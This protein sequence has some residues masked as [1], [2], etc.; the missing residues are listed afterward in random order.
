MTVM[1]VPSLRSAARTA[2]VVGALVAA[3]APACTT[4]AKPQTKYVPPSPIVRTANARWT[5]QAVV[6]DNTNGDVTVAGDPAVSVVSVSFLPYALADTLSDGQAGVADVTSTVAF[7]DSGGAYVARCQTALADHGSALQG[8]TGCDIVVTVPE[9]SSA[10]GVPVTVTSLSGSVTIT[11]IVAPPGT[12]LSAY[13]ANGSV[14]ASGIVGGFSAHADNGTI[15]ASVTPTAGAIVSITSDNGSVSLRLPNDFSA[16][17]LAVTAMN[18]KV[19]VSGFDDEQPGQALDPSKLSMASR[20]R[21]GALA[22]S[23]VLATKYGDA[24]LSSQ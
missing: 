21:G 9:G 7:F 8:T 16:T 3:V 1:A 24:Q 10:H 13:A 4:T 23:I 19:S 6:V 11:N 14:S 22:E 12:V 17:A 20:S 5:S 18:G 15:D 2:G